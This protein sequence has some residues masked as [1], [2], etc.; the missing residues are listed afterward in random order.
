M[1]IQTFDELT[2]A[3]RQLSRQQKIKL[4]QL[5]DAEL[6]GRDV[7][8]E[9]DQALQAIYAANRGVTED[10]VMA[11]ALSAIHEYRADESARRP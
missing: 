2:R 5:L 8:K 9:F 1:A 7:D 11:D 3:I 10:E 4:W 6:V